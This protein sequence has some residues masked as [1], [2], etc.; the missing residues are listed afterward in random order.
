MTHWPTTIADDVAL[1]V[2]LNIVA[3]L[4]FT[5]VVAEPN[6][7]V[8]TNDVP[9]IE[10]MVPIAPPKPPPKPPPPPKPLPPKPPALED[11]V[12]AGIGAP[13]TRPLG[14]VPLR[15]PVPPKVN[16]GQPEVL[17]TETFVAVITVGVLAGLLP[18]VLLALVT[19][20][21]SPVAS[22]AS[23]TDDTFVKR[24]EVPHAM[25]EVDVF[26]CTDAFVP[27][28]E[29]SLPETSTK[30]AAKFGWLLTAGDAAGAAEPAEELLPQPTA[31]S[32]TAARP[33]A[34]PDCRRD[35]R[36]SL[37]LVLSDM[38]LTS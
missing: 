25:G 36:R 13:L 5:V 3:E 2:V 30:L 27:E 26:D 37:N 19:E 35:D 21:Q 11:P 14:G 23:E 32:A 7:G 8:T 29:T 38:S 15:G 12:G 1:D 20:T 33:R 9:E 31:T 4:V 34:D 17:V 24:V 22:E 10:A 16:F 28:T 6:L 18:A